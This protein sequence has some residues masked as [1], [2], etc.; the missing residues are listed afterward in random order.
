MKRLLFALTLV[1]VFAAVSFAAVQDFGV[2]TMDVPEGWTASQQGPTAIVTKN[3]NTAS[4]TIT[5]AETQGYSAADLSAAF[6]EN[7]KNSGNFA[8]V[9]TPEADS[10]GDYSWVMTNN[11]GVESKAVL[12]VADKN[13]ILFVA[14]G[15]A[16]AP[17]D[18]GTMLG[19][20]KEK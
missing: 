9:G 11:Q 16:N 4:L 5:V 13:Y 1:A 7:F 15:M 8:S 17:E 3:D 10:D 12:S 14:T 19:S 18:F 2:F 6:V 20:V